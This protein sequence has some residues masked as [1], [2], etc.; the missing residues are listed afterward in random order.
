MNLGKE[1]TLII[2]AIVTAATAVQVAAIHMSTLAH[3]VVAI[4]VI[5]LGALV[6]RQAVTPVVSPVT[7]RH[8]TPPA[9]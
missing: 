6:N 7:V 1:P 3:T 5:G 4:V 2:Q 9:P 8:R